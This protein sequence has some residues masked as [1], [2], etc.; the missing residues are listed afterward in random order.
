MKM[1]ASEVAPCTLEEIRAWKQLNGYSVPELFDKYGRILYNIWFNL[2]GGKGERQDFTPSEITDLILWLHT[3]MPREHRN[4]TW[5]NGK[6]A[7]L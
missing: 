7:S 4:G 3:T 6:S 2:E 1:E 5:L